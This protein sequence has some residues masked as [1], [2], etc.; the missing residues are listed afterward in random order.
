MI[1][2][3]KPG[4]I[5]MIEDGDLASATS[6]P[7]SAMDAFADL[8]GRLGESRGLNY[9]VANDLYHL[10]KDAG[11]TDAKL[12]MHQ[13]A[14]LEGPNRVFL[15]WSVEE[16]GPSL[17]NAGILNLDELARTLAQMQEVVE[18]PEVVILAPRMSQVWA[19]K[20]H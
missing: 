4:G 11:F 8:F 2:V 7:K 9:S 13:P 3:L 20:A 5:L 15:K 18:N 19:R 16:A 14:I 12:E 17:L 1:A 6:V 10:V